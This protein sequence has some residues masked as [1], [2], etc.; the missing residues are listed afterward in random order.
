MIWSIVVAMLAIVGSAL[1]MRSAPAF[2]TA[3][4]AAAAVLGF[5]L[6]TWYVR[7]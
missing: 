5:G 2:T 6:L 3:A 1:V 7:E 4:L